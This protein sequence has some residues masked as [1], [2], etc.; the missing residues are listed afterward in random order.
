M[1][2]EPTDW[3]AVDAPA[4]VYP[5]SSSSEI[6]PLRRQTSRYPPGVPET[7]SPAPSPRASPVLGSSGS[8]ADVV[9]QPVELPEAVR[10]I[11]M[12]ADALHDTLASTRNT[13][14]RAMVLDG[15]SLPVVPQRTLDALEEWARLF[16]E[17]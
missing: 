3:P 1:P 10:R 5:E 11:Y 16:R 14:E 12:L 2:D 13:R 17:G 15:V 6:A 4:S 8:V 9:E 7:P